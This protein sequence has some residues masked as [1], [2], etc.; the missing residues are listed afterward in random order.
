MKTRFFIFT[1]LAILPGFAVAAPPKIA[2]IATDPALRTAIAQSG[3]QILDA[4]ALANADVLVLQS[5][6]APSLWKLDR[7]GLEAF[8]AKGGGVVLIGGAIDAGDWPK[9]LAGGVR[10]ASSRQFAGPMM[11]Y[12]LT[13]AHPITREASAFDL[14]DNTAYDLELDASI[15]VLASAFTPKV[16]SAKKDNRAPEQLDRANVY[17]I[18]PQMWAYE[19]AD[20]HRA[21]VLLQGGAESLKHANV[22]E[23]CAKADLA[24][25]RDPQGGPR[26]AAETVK[27]FDLHPD[28]KATAIASEPLIN[29]PI[30]MLWDARGRLWIAET[31]EYPNGRRPLVEVAWKET[32]VLKPDQYDLPAT[33]RI[34]ILEDTNGDGVMDKKTVFFEG[35][36]LVTGFCLIKQGRGI[37]ESPAAA[38]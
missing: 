28:F 31:P 13:D 4:S 11:L 34:S 16:T 10:T 38:P 23:L 9:P 22:D 20:K 33:D 25:L 12:P 17:D 3:A 19:G 27:S 2:V 30:A 18:Q 5:A 6:D 37:V 36:E 15:T 7:A 14:A 29:K 26:R 1:L 8:A 21:F 32:G 24:T 35:L